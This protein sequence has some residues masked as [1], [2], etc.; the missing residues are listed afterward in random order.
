VV[1][2]A[3]SAQVLVTTHSRTLAG[4]I[5]ALSPGARTIALHLVQGETRVVDQRLVE[6]DEEGTNGG[7]DE[8]DEDADA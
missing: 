5:E 3:G 6:D 1:Q 8:A 7:D 4:E 2:A